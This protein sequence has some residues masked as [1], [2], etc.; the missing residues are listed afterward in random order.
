MTENSNTSPWKNPA[1]WGR[2]AFAILYLVVLALLVVPL[3]IVLCLAQA[4]FTIATGGDNRNLRGLAASLTE[5]S[6]EIL[7]FASWNREAKPFPFA[8]FP[9]VAEADGPDGATGGADAEKPAHGAEP[10]AAEPPQ[11]A[12][13]GGTR[14]VPAA[15]AKTDAGTGPESGAA[16]DSGADSD[17]RPGSDTADAPAPAAGESSAGPSASDA[18]STKHKQD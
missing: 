14:A 10:G 3:A 18:D 4:V 2:I 11:G 5:Y 1:I 6:A 13:A 12:A 15:K 7:R 8:D 16:P 9:S 17:A